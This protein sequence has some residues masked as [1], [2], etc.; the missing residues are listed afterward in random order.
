VFKS[1]K[2]RHAIH[3]PALLIS[4]NLQDPA[5]LERLRQERE[6]WLWN[7]RVEMLDNTHAMHVVCPGGIRRVR[8]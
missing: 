6:A 2:R 8:R 1:R 4:H 7:S 5:A 3:A